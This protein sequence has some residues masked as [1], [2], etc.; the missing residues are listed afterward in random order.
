MYNVKIINKKK[1]II[2]NLKLEEKTFIVHIVSL[3]I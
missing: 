2:K 3:L 1:F